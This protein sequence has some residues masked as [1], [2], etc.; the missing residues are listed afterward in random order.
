MKIIGK[1]SPESSSEVVASGSGS[2]GSKAE[3]NNEETDEEMEEEG[4]E[5]GDSSPESASSSG[6]DIAD[7]SDFQDEL[8][9]KQG[10]YRYTSGN[11]QYKPKEQCQ[12]C[13]LW[14]KMLKDHLFRHSGVKN[15]EC[16]T[17]GKK[18]GHKTHLKNHMMMHLD[19]RTAKCE[20]CF[21]MF[22]NAYN[23]KNHMIV[24]DKLKKGFEPEFTCEICNSKFCHKES[25]RHHLKMHSQV[26]KKNFSKL[27]GLFKKVYPRK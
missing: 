6:E 13:G 24:H 27:L 17:C 25:I 7:D 10:H 14:F 15:F 19:I 9:A 21:K 4:Q 18:F 20:V 12:I 5:N 16:E 3:D 1:P 11:K 2:A 8:K 22:R 26:L 23:L